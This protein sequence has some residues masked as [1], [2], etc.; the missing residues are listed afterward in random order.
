MSLVP[1]R[2][3]PRRGA[4]LLNLRVRRA[5]RECIRC[6]S[7]PLCSHTHK[8]FHTTHH[9]TRT[10]TQP[11]TRP[12]WYGCGARGEPKEKESAPSTDSTP[13]R[14]ALSASSRPLVAHRPRTMSGTKQFH[15]ETPFPFRHFVPL[16]ATL[17]FSKAFH[18][19][20]PGSANA[21]V[22]PPVLLVLIVAGWGLTRVPRRR[23][24]P[25]H[26][27]DCRRWPRIM[28]P[29]CWRRT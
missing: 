24:Q 22:R 26:T 2:S 5:R 18:T 12:P 9:I 17:A 1:S 16:I 3:A 23:A 8:F 10:H 20:S 21:T 13:L 28:P 25:D 19:A 11:H 14:R 7:S 15:H 29:W 4:S 27:T 6:A